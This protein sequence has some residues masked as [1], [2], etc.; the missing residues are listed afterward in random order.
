MFNNSWK[1]ASRVATKDIIIGGRFITYNGT[2]IN[3][4]ARLNNNGALDTKFNAGTGINND[5]EAIFVQTDG[6]ILVGGNFTNYNGTSINRIVRLNIDG[7]IDNDFTV[8]TGFTGGAAAIRNITMQNDSKIIV[9]GS[10]TL[11]NNV[12]RNRIARL[13]SDGS[14]DTTFNPGTGFN[15]TVWNSEIQNDGKIIMGGQFTTYNGTAINRII[16]VNT[17]GSLDTSFNVGT[18][19][20]NYPRRVRIQDDG[21]ILVGGFFTVYNGTSINRIARLN[22]DGSLDTSFNVGTGFDN[23]PRNIIIQ[24]DR[25]ILI[26]GQFDVYNGTSVNRFTR[27]NYDG[28]IDTDFAIGTG[29]NDTTHGIKIQPDGKILITGFFTTYNGLTATRIVR[30]NTNGG[31]DPTF[32]GDADNIPFEIDLLNGE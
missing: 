21:K 3:R 30:L 20:D 10:F 6:K 26:G 23:A 18:G 1:I 9:S 19:F 17:D 5:I 16:R 14:L 4:I 22:T 32:S 28:S 27:L 7:T 13:N 2:S 24:N 11:F 12:S 31:I 15:S 25:K 29:F 8:G